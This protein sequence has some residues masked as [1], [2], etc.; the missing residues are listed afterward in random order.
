[1]AQ[2]DVDAYDSD[3]LD[4]AL[5]KIRPQQ[6]HQREASPDISSTD[7]SEDQTDSDNEEE[8]VKPPTPKKPKQTAPQVSACIFY[9][10]F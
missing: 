10:L 2:D 8:E 5:A 1:M 7:E 6:Q 3:D 9:Y 4:E